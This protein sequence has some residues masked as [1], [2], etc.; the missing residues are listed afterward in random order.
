MRASLARA[1]I[2]PEEVGYINAH[3]TGTP[4][5]DRY[6]TVAIQEVFGAHTEQLA[7]SSTKSMT[8]HMMGAAGAFEGFVCVRV[9]Q[10]GCLPPTIN[11]RH[12]D[13]D[14]P[15][16]YVPNEAR[17]ADVRVALSNSMGLGGHNSTVIVRRFEE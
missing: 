2:G 8:G 3:G 6:E 9:V 11:Y 5:N 17:Q 15:L 13:P 7:V 1:G 16:D 4:L 10:T 12:P 14:L